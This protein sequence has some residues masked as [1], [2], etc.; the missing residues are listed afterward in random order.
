MRQDAKVRAVVAAGLLVAGTTGVL[1]AQAPQPREQPGAAGAAAAAR[2]DANANADAAR[3]GQH[4]R[5]M[6]AYALYTA[7]DGSELHFAARAARGGQH[8]HD[9][10]NRADNNQNANDRQGQDEAA[11][12]RM[13]QEGQRVAEQLQRQ[14][15]RQFQA[16]EH[17]LGA[18]QQGLGAGAD[19]A[20]RAE[21][22]DAW[23]QRLYSVASQYTNSL[24][25]ISGAD[26]AARSDSP[27]GAADSGR[28]NDDQARGGERINRI[29]AAR[30]VLVNQAVKEALAAS[31]LRREIR[32][33]GA[34]GPMAQRL[35]ER[36]QEMVANSEQVLQQVLADSNSD[37]GRQ[38][39]GAGNDPNAAGRQN[40]G[41]GNDNNANPRQNPGQGNEANA[42]DR[43][44]AGQGDANANDRQNAGQ[45]DNNNAN[46]RQNAGRDNAQG[47]G[48]TSVRELAQQAQ[49]L[50]QTLERINSG[51]AGGEQGAGERESR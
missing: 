50:V 30:V 26:Q 47:Q 49:Q 43:Q 44:N 16:S 4:T 33:H 21:G 25:A 10:A 22:R 35:Q 2:G 12:Q 45:G 48:R 19:A 13:Q 17:L 28:G 42:N 38:A 41:Q 27:S 31:D 46:D 3:H 6:I 36:A 20:P 51:E 32:V 34:Q 7:I 5:R 40:A 9:A 15:D 39:P 18:A 14:A 37:A 11:R 24:R 1:F 29:D 23:S 8:Q